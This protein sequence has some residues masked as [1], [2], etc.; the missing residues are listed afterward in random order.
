MDYINKE[1]SG[2]DLDGEGWIV[3]L[4]EHDITDL[5]AISDFEDDREWHGPIV[6][7][8]LDHAAAEE[9]WQK[10]FT[11]PVNHLNAAPL[12]AKGSVISRTSGSGIPDLLH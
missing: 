2:S 11:K 7:D 4:L 8:N 1:D 5:G 9:F 6:N 12:K 3:S 10:I